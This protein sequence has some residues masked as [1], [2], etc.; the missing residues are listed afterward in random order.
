M[1]HPSAHIFCR[2]Q[3]L[4]E[5]EKPISAKEEWEMLEKVRG[6]PI[7]YRVRDPKKDDFDTYLMKPRQ[8]RISNYGV[9][10]WEVA[11]DI[12]FRE[13]TKYDKAKDDTIDDTVVTDEIRHTKFLALPA[14]SVFAVEDTISERS[15]GA[16]SAVGRFT[17]IVETLM[18]TSNIAPN[19]V[20]SIA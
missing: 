7:A 4:D 8:K 10:T 12:K 17:A 11:Q 2:Y 13:R 14:L 20:L 15:L 19:C 3:I 16:R 18:G 9:H 1:A 5:E 6:Q